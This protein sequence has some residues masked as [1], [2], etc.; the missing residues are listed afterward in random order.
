MTGTWIQDIEQLQSLKEEFKTKI[1]H[2]VVQI[3]SHHLTG[4]L[5]HCDKLV[6]KLKTT[7]SDI[8]S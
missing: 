3:D 7:I 8:L 1:K 2:S 6:P 4:Y 5:N